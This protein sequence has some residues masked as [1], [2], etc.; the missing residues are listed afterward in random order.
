[1]NT[2]LYSSKH[3]VVLRTRTMSNGRRLGEIADAEMVAIDPVL[4]EDLCHLAVGAAPEVA[5]AEKARVA[6]AKRRLAEA[7]RGDALEAVREARDRLVQTL[8]E[9]RAAGD[10]GL[11]LE[12]FSGVEASADDLRSARTL[13]RAA[14]RILESH[15]SLIGECQA[16]DPFAPMH[17][18]ID[19][20][21]R[22]YWRCTHSPE[23]QV[24]A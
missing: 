4:G 5:M 21:G 3:C 17:L 24:P 9:R 8:S 1:M 20:H 22:L 15:A 10:Y 7:L 23:H 2:E 13:A 14:T 18:V 19:H 16:V 11:Q 6:Q 12:T